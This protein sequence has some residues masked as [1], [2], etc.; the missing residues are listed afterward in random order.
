MGSGIVFGFCQ[1]L[2]TEKTNIP[3]S[4]CD[5][6][7]FFCRKLGAGFT[8]MSFVF[9]NRVINLRKF[10][11]IIF[12]FLNLWKVWYHKIKGWGHYFNCVI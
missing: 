7:L 1:E 6:V 9:Y 12:N 8:N 4:Q 3:P 2:N 11:R 10:F 5:Q